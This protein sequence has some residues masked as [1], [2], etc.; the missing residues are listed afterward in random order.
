MFTARTISILCGLLAFSCLSL[1]Q[2]AGQHPSRGATGSRLIAWS[3]L[4]K[5]IPIPEQPGSQVQPLATAF[6]GVI[7]NANGTYRLETTDHSQY[8]LDN[9][10]VVK[11]YVG[12]HV[13]LIGSF[14][15]NT[16]AVHVVTIADSR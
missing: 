15:A 1:G 4:Q 10:E 14:D 12:V 13:Q 7:S 3:E 9:H 16:G 5:P 11:P 2:E 6:S 8:L